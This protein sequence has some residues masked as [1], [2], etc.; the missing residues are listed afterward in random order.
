MLIGALSN[1]KSP[2][3][4]LSGLLAT[5]TA[6][7]QQH[8]SLNFKRIKN[9]AELDTALQ[10]AQGKLVMLDFYADWCVSCKEMDQFT[11]SDPR[12]QTA[13]KDTVLLQADVTANTE[14]DKALL[15]K[16]NLFGPP[17]ILFFN[18]K[19]QLETNLKVVGYQNADDF[20]QTLNQRGSCLPET[21]QC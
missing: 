5:G 17:G 11:F 12:V 21:F 1:A 6:T 14:D 20:L 8:S 16:F 18:T 13:L 15:Q 9:L 4:P 19:A 3:Q 2:L 10:A 7:Q